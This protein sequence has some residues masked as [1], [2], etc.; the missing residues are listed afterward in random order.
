[1]SPYERLMIEKEKEKIKK[2]DS[3]RL[4]D[5][6]IVKKSNNLIVISILLNVFVALVIKYGGFRKLWGLSYNHI[7]KYP[8]VHNWLAKRKAFI[9]I[10][11][12]SY[13][14]T[15]PLFWLFTEYTTIPGNAIGIIFGAPFSI[16]LLFMLPG[17]FIF[18]T[19]MGV[20]G[21]SFL[22]SYYT[23]IVTFFAVFLMIDGFAFLSKKYA[24]IYAKTKKI[25][26]YTSILF[27]LTG[28]IG[29]LFTQ[30]KM[31]FMFYI[32]TVG[33]WIEYYFLKKIL[34]KKEK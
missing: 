19:N 18:I 24:H 14:F 30:N 13:L 28:W 27:G 8:R 4:E 17:M 12:A 34:R 10:F 22:W 11:L 31:Y 6:D 20:T 33:I 9:I 25:I 5:I 2:S 21:A 15:L 7:T 3:A 16:L 29:L 32:L 26:Q 1:M 23:S